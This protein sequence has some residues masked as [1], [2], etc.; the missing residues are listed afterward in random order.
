MLKHIEQGHLEG[1]N[2]K[3]STEG[4]KAIGRCRGEEAFSWAENA[5]CSVACFGFIL[6]Y[7]VEMR[8]PLKEG[9]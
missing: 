2:K 3:N 8:I 9:S 4:L 7:L 5:S 1:L 6:Q